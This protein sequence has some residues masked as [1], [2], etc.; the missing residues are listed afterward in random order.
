M[1][2]DMKRI[3]SASFRAGWAAAFLSIADRLEK[4][5]ADARMVK[6]LRGQAEKPPPVEF[7]DREEWPNGLPGDA[8]WMERFSKKGQS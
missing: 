2:Q 4:T 6:A 3:A 1:D 8:V 5:G 7:G